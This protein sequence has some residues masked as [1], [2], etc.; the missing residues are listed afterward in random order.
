MSGA[1][2]FK[3]CLNPTEVLIGWMDGVYI[4]VPKCWRIASLICSTEPNKKRVGNEATENKNRDAQKKQSMYGIITIGIT[5][6]VQEWKNEG[7]R[8]STTSNEAAKL[9][10]VA[11]S[12]VFTTANRLS[13]YRL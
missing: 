2:G 4:R 9:Y 13:Y 12:Q 8:L 7:L 10:D 1:Y 11:I 3:F 6:A 5:I